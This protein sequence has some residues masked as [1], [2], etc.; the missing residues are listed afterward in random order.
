DVDTDAFGTQW[1]FAYCSRATAS[2]HVYHQGKRV[3]L[4]VPGGIYL[5]PFSLVE[6]H[7]GVGDVWFYAL[8]LN[9]PEPTNAPEAAE[10]FSVVLTSMPRTVS[11]VE[12]ALLARRGGFPIGRET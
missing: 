1:S 3:R 2:V 7:V 6:W 9:G 4:P 8:N 5:P 12:E 10:A 11:E